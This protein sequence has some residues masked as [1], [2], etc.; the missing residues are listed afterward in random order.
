MDKHYRPHGEGAYFN[1]FDLDEEA[2]FK[3]LRN[4]EITTLNV[5]SSVGAHALLIVYFYRNELSEEN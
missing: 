2:V 1:D 4:P 5:L 3:F